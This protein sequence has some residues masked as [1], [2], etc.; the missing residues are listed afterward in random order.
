MAC[1]NK[2]YSFCRQPEIWQFLSKKNYILVKHSYNTHTHSH[3]HFSP[4]SYWRK[5]AE[6]LYFYPLRLQIYTF[7][8]SITKVP[9]IWFL[10]SFKKYLIIQMIGAIEPLVFNYSL[11]KWYLH[12]GIQPKWSWGVLKL[13]K[14][15]GG[16][17]GWGGGHGMLVTSK[18]GHLHHYMKS[19]GD[20]SS[21]TL[22]LNKSVDHRWAPLVAL[23][24]WN[25]SRE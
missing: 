18:Q 21:R 3:Q 10:F 8:E 17:G 5:M 12:E 13:C 23:K 22:A 7:F 19:Y 9:L 14:H 15:G 11:D 25:L 6:P 24:L 20:S 1:R 16:W 4:V 2:F